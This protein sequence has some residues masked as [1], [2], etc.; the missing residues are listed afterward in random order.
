MYFLRKRYVKMIAALGR[1]RARHSAVLVPAVFHFA[2]IAEAV[3]ATTA[4]S[5][6]SKQ[7][8]T[9]AKLFAAW[10]QYVREQQDI[11]MA[12]YATFVKWI[13]HWPFIGFSRFRTWFG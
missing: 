11:A 2:N 6:Q 8:V 1:W 13:A 12:R 4:H 10:L 9:K 5:F 7:G 3:A